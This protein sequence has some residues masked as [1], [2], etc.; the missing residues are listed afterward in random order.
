MSAS[1]SLNPF[2]QRVWSALVAEYPQWS[3]HLRIRGQNDLEVA[4]Q[5]PA[6]SEAG[7]LVIFT[8]EGSDLWVRFSPPSACYSA[9]DEGEMLSVIR[10][11]LS[12]SI[13]FAVTMRGDKWV[14]T[15][16]IQ[17]TDQP[18]PSP[19]EKTQIYSWSGRHDRTI[20]SS[21]N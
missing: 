17:R 10:G 12:E 20:G 8:S 14:Q 2:A 9:D 6:E 21:S 16:L 7:W 18:Q 4:V 3:E 13:L 1:N 11:L 5:A 15:T 19:G